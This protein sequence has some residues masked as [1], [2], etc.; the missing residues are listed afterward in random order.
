MDF[1]QAVTSGL[2][3]FGTWLMFSGM[4]LGVLESLIY[5]VQLNR[6]LD[7]LDGIVESEVAAENDAFFHRDENQGQQVQTAPS[8]EQMAGITVGLSA[9][10]HQLVSKR[11]AAKVAVQ[12]A[13]AAG[14]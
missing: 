9:D 13:S 2:A 11:R 1:F 4:C 3:A 14:A 8:I 6:M 10:L 5:D 12:S 7:Q